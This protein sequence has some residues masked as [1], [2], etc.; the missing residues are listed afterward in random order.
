MAFYITGDCH[1]EFSKIAF[2]CEHH[3]TSIKD[4]MIILGDFGVNHW[5]GEKDVENKKLLAQI[6]LTFFAVHGNHEARPYEI[7]GYVER[8]WCGGI[9][10]IEPQYPNIL[11]AK[12]GEIYTL[13]D[14][15]CMAIGG[16]YSVDKYHR[17]RVGLPWFESEQPSSE[18]KSFVEHQLKSID[19]KID[20]VFSHTCPLK[21]EPSDLF[22]D[23]VK[24]NY[25]K[26]D[27]STEE[28][29][30]WLE[31]KINYEK[32]Y[33]GHFHANRIFLRAELLFDTIKELGSEDFIQRVG[34]PKFRKGEMVLFYHDTGKEK[35][36]HYGKI[37]IIDSYGTWGQ[38]KEVS[39]DIMGMDERALFK[40]VV[41]SDVYGFQEINEECERYWI[42]K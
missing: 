36:E 10:Y 18:I 22:L 21:Y 40:H 31:E 32:W 1:G 12:D 15:K 33:F 8:E 4:V 28:W 38:C 24:F 16:A 20:Y 7:E 27:T 37:E 41:E 14:K 19:Y 42:Q 25:E 6:P 2:F 9:V 3:K 26:A 34:R 39:Y 23:F 29:L 30:T 13:G 5:L 11:F 35:I 17:L